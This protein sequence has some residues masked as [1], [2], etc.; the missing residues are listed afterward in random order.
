MGHDTPSKETDRRSSESPEEG[1]A[2]VMIVHIQVGLSATLEAWL[3]QVMLNNQSAEARIESKLD[4]VLERLKTMSQLDDRI[5]ALTERVRGN[6]SVVEST[7]ELV[8][9]IPALIDAGIQKALAAGATEQQLSALSALSEE[10]QTED[11]GL[12]ADLAAAVAANTPA[13]QA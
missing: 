7:R 3:Q 8:R 1:T 10:L 5:A 13:A 12:A 11:T 2:A 4:A 9:G 6:T